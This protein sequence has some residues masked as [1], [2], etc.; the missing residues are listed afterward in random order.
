LRCLSARPA[1]IFAACH[2]NQGQTKGPRMKAHWPV[3]IALIVGVLAAYPS[4]AVAQSVRLLG[5]FRDW[6]A[7]ATSDSA[8]KLCFVLSKPTATEPQPD[9]YGQAYLYLTHRPGEQV[10]SELNII[11]GYSFSPDSE[12]ILQVGGESY[13]LFTSDDAAWLLDPAVAEDVAGSMRAGSSMVVEGTNERG[14]KIRQTFS[15]SGITAA[16]RAIDAECY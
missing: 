9:G 16:S 8:G 12:A 7:Y 14:I 10:R 2:G 4:L 11:A 15:L 13:T 3:R 1:L 6:S 5:D